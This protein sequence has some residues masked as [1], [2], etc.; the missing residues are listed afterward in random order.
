MKPNQFFA[1][2]GAAAFALSSTFA[3]GEGWTSDFAAAKKQAASEKKDLL[4]DFTGSDWCS[5][6]IKL[7]NEVF[8]HDPF[9]EGVKDKFVLVELDYPEDESKLTEATIKQNK[10]L[11][12]KYSIQGYPTILLCD[13]EGRPYAGTGYQEGG[14]EKYVEHLDELRKKKTARDEQFAKA[15][16]AE[17]VARAKALIAALEEM[18][19]A[20]EAVSEFY[21]DVVKDIKAADPKDET[22]FVKKL[23]AKEK[24]IDLQEKLSEFAEKE[25]HEGALA[26]I[27]K[28]ADD[29]DGEVKQQVVATQAMILAHLE[30]FDES[31]K[32]LDEAKKISP[33]SE[34][35]ERID[36][37]KEQISEA[38]E[39]SKEA[40]KED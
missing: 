12:E 18:G 15:E 21:G 5:W 2:I 17:G 9:K 13:A 7:S 14:A 16:S 24:L 33:E 26:F 3:A 39:A 19:L 1:A 23:E 32:T 11:Q 40:P 22:G 20:D 25:D 38:K 27:K 35:A 8:K 37:L 4:L 31:I 10:E 34:L 36:G 6:C 30:R 28:A 29:F